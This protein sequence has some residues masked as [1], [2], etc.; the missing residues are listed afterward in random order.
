MNW[1]R[2][3][4]TWYEH[5]VRENMAKW[6]AKWPKQSLRTCIFSFKLCALW[7][8]GLMML[9]DTESDES[10]TNTTIG[11]GWSEVSINLCDSQTPRSEKHGQVT[12]QVT[13]AIFADVYI[14]VQT[15]RTMKPRT[16]DVSRYGEWR[17]WHKH[18]DR[19]R[20]IRGDQRSQSTCVIPK[21]DPKSS[22]KDQ[23]IFKKPCKIAPKTMQKRDQKET[24]IGSKNGSKTTPKST[25]KSIQNRLQ[26]SSQKPL[27]PRAKK[28]DTSHAKPPFLGQPVLTLERE[29]RNF[30]T[31]NLRY[32]D[33][34]KFPE[35]PWRMQTDTKGQTEK[36]LK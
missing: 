12:G 28:S 19:N 36:P 32:I 17:K 6:L 29:A 2:I 24:K 9:A 23:K 26:K 35:A 14:L 3:G 11:T 10:G 34:N 4:R 20:M 27:P 33:I 30:E 25:S 18:H 22:K 31:M 13:E 1:P 5:H 21:M 8:Q 16:H 15:L 7:N